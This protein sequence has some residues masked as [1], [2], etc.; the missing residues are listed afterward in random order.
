[1]QDIHRLRVLGLTIAPACAGLLLWMAV[2]L[3]RR[4]A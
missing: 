3:W 2:A 4:R 1:V